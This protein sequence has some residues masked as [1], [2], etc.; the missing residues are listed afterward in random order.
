MLT[1]YPLM[2]SNVRREC[3]RIAGKPPRALRQLAGRLG[4]DW[5]V[6]YSDGKW[7]LFAQVDDTYYFTVTGGNTRRAKGPFQV[8]LW[9]GNRRANVTEIESRDAIV[10]VCMHMCPGFG[11]H[12]DGGF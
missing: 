11:K 9:N 6:T 4:E 2:T 5:H 12:D 3:E 1:P 7:V 8:V 10:G